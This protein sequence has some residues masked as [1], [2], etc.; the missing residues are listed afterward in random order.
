MDN[1]YIYIYIYKTYYIYIYIRRTKYI[2]YVFIYT[3]CN[4]TPERAGALEA[5]DPPVVRNPARSGVG[6]EVVYIN[7][8]NIYNTYYR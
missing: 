6:L 7:T 1:I 8:Y 2:L 4:P 3:T 5:T